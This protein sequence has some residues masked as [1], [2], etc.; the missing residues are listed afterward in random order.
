M[1]RLKKWQ[2][3]KILKR[4]RVNKRRN[5]MRNETYITTN[6]QGLYQLINGN[7]ESE[8]TWDDYED[9]KDALKADNELQAE[10]N[11]KDEQD[12]YNDNSAITWIA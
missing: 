6:D 9:A 8:E 3:V 2:K 7:V 4:K 5:D 12:L 11:G 10:A 1:E